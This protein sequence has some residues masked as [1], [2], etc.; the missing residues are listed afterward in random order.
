M[1]CNVV[2]SRWM[3]MT[4]MLGPLVIVAMVGCTHLELEDCPDSKVLGNN[5]LGTARLRTSHYRVVLAD[6]DAAAARVVP[7]ALM[8]ARTLAIMSRYL[9]SALLNLSSGWR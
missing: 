1:Q 2:A 4:R 5:E 3:Q 6:R 7:Y 8:S 9:P